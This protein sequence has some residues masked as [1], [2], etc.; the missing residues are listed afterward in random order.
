MKKPTGNHGVPKPGEPPDE[1]RT[2]L[3]LGLATRAGKTAAGYD[4]V[5]Q[6]VLSGKAYLILCATDAS[7]NT[8]R[9]IGRLAQETDTPF[10]R[11]STRDKLG[12]FTGK[13]DRAVVC[14]LD[15]G[16]SERLITMI[17]DKE[18]INDKDRSVDANG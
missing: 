8:T 6:S 9:R 18:T 10:R 7:E 13:E 11:F 15:K 17:P 16:F 2:L 1:N 3:F 12:R 5:S 14:I 4:I